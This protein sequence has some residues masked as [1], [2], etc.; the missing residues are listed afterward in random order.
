MISL[1][2][3]FSHPLL[4]RE[5]T[6][7]AA[8]K[9]TYAGRVVYGL[10]LYTLFIIALR[11]LIGN[12][13]GDPTGFGVLGLGRGMFQQLVELQCW[14][15]FLFQPALM[16]GVITYEKERESF[17][18]L[19]LTGMSPTKILIEK[20]LAGLFPMA[21]LL[22]LALPLG[23]ITMGYGGVSP[24][25]LASGACVVLAAWLQVG[26]FS[27]LCSAWC[28]TTVG[29]ML[30]AYLGGALVYLAPAIGY[31]LAVR[32][33]LWGADVR[34]LEIPG[35]LWSLW[36]PEV[37][38]RVLAFQESVASL[39]E[40]DAS[41]LWARL[42][43][44]T[45]RLCAPL[46][47]SAGVFLLL[48][49]IVMVR[50]ALVVAA[51]VRRRADR[52]KRVRLLPSAAASWLHSLWPKHTNLPQDDP[53]AWRESG[54][55]LLGRRGRFLQSTLIA[56]GLALALSLFL[57][58]LYPRTAGP[59]RLHHLSIV[60][61]VT[62]VLVLTVRSVGALLS[63]HAN[64]TLDILLTTPLGAAEILREK[65]RALGRYWLLFALPLGVVFALEGWSEYQ[66][67]RAETIWRDLGLYWICDALALLI[68][69]PLII[70][71]SLLFALWLRARSRAIVATLMLFAMWFIAPLT[72][73]SLMW[74]Q[75]RTAQPGLWLSL[76]SPLGIVDANEGGRLALFS[77]RLE[78]HGRWTVGWAEPWVPIVCNFLA[79][80][81][82]LL[83]V[84]W[85][86]LRMAEP[87]LHRGGPSR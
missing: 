85:L 19:L 13:S 48:A 25:L 76:L 36:P 53:I 34:G 22:L 67:V 16:A 64:Q 54:R 24:Q 68:Y 38:A 72:V 23:A 15:V 81:L 39:G 59:E 71:A 10:V 77:L 37:F 42:L 66:Y 32:Y 80:G 29:A 43:G 82:L 79:Y 65:A 55:S 17:S 21:T 60:L 41:A 12:A 52:G 31:S 20:Y 73:L 63:E 56:A 78:K 69:P 44:E 6:E 75:W 30:A 51:D 74:P 7:R 46:L 45:G 62:T 4:A 35:W 49:R 3:I 61:G 40:P 8:R 9:R 87:W 70:W 47:I 86:C 50:R 5:L 14:G 1:R 84:R 57:L 27:L 2:S 33:V 11:R 28:R 26:A 83:C 18:L 58:G